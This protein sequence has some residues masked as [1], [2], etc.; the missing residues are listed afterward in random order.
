MG[1]TSPFGKEP[2]LYAS[3]FEGEICFIKYSAKTLRAELPVQRKRIL[4]GSALF[5]I[6]SFEHLSLHVDRTPF[7]TSSVKTLFPKYHTKNRLTFCG[8]PRDSGTFEAKGHE[9]AT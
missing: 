4:N 3:N 7:K 5:M 9:A 2:A 8:H 1:C 6:G